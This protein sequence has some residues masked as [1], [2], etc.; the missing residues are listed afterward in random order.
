MKKKTAFIALLSVFAIGSSAGAVMASGCSGSGRRI[1]A[2]TELEA[3][4][5]TYVIPDYDVVDNDGMILSGYNV[6]LKSVKDAD[7]E[8]LAESYGSAVTVDEAGVYSF[9][10]SAGTR[11]VKDVTVSIDFADRTA[12]V[13]NCDDSSIPK[14]FIPGNSYKVPAYTLS[15]DFVREKCWAKVFYIDEN[16]KET[17]VKVESGRFKVDKDSGTYEIRIH[18]E[19]AAGNPNDYKYARK[20]ESPENVVDNKVLYLDEKFGEKQVSC[21]QSSYTGGFISKDEEGAHAYEGESGSYKVSFNGETPTQYNEGLIVMDVPAIIDMNEYEELYMYVY[22][23]SEN[24]IIMGSQWWNDTKVPA[25]QWTKLTWNTRAWGNNMSA[26]NTKPIGLVDITGMTIRFVFDYGQKI[27]PN[28]DFYLSAMY[29]TPKIRTELE[30]GE[31]VSLNGAKYFI[32]DKIELNAVQIEGKTVDYYK[33][34]G[35]IIPG[36]SFIA[37]EEKH[38]IEVVYADGEL[39]NDNM[40]W[41]SFDELKPVGGDVQTQYMGNSDYWVMSYDVSGVNDGWKYFGVYVGGNDQ[42]VGIELSDQQHSK[43][44]GYGGAWKWG[45]GVKLPDEVYTLLRTESEPVKAVFVRAGDEIRCFIISKEKTYFV[46]AVQFS[47][48]GVSGNG[49]GYGGRSNVG[50]T[51]ENFKAVSGK[52]KTELYF[53]EYY[54]AQL[55]I[56]NVKDDGE[57]YL[58]DKVTLKPAAAPEGKLFAYI[59]VNGKR[60]YGTEFR[61]PSASTSVKIV[62]TDISEVTLGEGIVTSDGKNGLIEVP[63][64]TYVIFDYK[65]KAPSG[66]YFVG[67]KVDG[68]EFIGNEILIT[69]AQ[70]TIEPLFADKVETGGEKLNDISDE[71]VIYAKGDDEQVKWNPESVEY[72]TDFT[73]DGS[74]KAVDESGVL[75]IVTG[76]DSGENSFAF[77]NSLVENLDAYKEIYF[78]VYTEADGVKAGGWWC[79]DTALVP[80]KWTRVSF[81]RNLAPGTIDGNGDTKVWEEGIN[82]FAFRIM[83]AP[84]GITVYVTAAY[85]LPYPDATVTVADD[86]KDSL[87]VSAPANGRNYKVNETVTLTAAPDPEGLTFAYFTANGEPIEGNTYLIT[88][89]VEF[90][91]VYSEYSTLALDDGISTTDGKTGTIRVARN[92]PVYLKLTDDAKYYVAFSVNGEA[93]VGNSFIPTE[94]ITYEVTVETA[95]KNTS[96]SSQLNDVSSAAMHDKNAKL[97]FTDNVYYNGADGAVTNGGSLKITAGGGDV[98]VKATKAVGGE[99]SGYKEV[100]FYIYTLDDGVVAGTWWCNDTAAV[101]GQWTKVTVYADN[102]KNTNNNY[103]ADGVSGRLFAA[104]SKGSNF[105]YRIMGGEGK[106]VY[107]TS[108]YG[109][110]YADATVKIADDSKDSL[111][112]SDPANG[113]QYKESE[114]VT[115]TAATAPEG[116][117]FAYFTANGEPIEGSTY[118]LGAGEVTFGVVYTDISVITFGEGVTAEGA[119]DGKLT[120]GRSATVTLEFNGTVP[121]GKYFKGFAVDS[122]LIAG[123]TFKANNETHTVEAVFEDKIQTGSDKLNEI[124]TVAEDG[125]SYHPTQPDWAPEKIEYVTDVKYTGSDGAIDENGSLKVTLKGGEQA[126]ALNKTLINELDVYKEIY[127]YIY[128]DKGADVSGIKIGGWWCRDTDIVAGQWTRVSF[129]R[130]KAPQNVSEKSVWAENSIDKFVYSFEKAKAGTVVYLT[131]VY[132]VLYDEVSV[133]VEESVKNYIEVTGT[134]REGQTITLSHKSSP[135]NTEFV[136]FTVNGERYD[137]DTYTLGTA[138]VVIGAYFTEAKAVLTFGE[139]VKTSDGKNAYALGETVTL[140]IDGA[141]APSD[142]VL[143]RFEVDGKSIS[144]NTFTTTAAAHSVTAVFIDKAADMTW[145]E[146]TTDGTEEANAGESIFVKKFGNAD[147]WVMTYKVT[148]LSSGDWGSLLSVYIG[149][150]S[151]ILQISFSGSE[152]TARVYGQTYDSPIT[153]NNITLIDLIKNASAENPVDVTFVRSGNNIGVY[154]TD[155]NNVT[156]VLVNVNIGNYLSSGA[157]TDDFGYA[158]RHTHYGNPVIDI[159]YVTGEGKTGLFLDSLTADIGFTKASAEQSVYHLG[160]TVTLIAE[161]AE[162]GKK[163]LRFTVNDEPLT[164]NTF[165]VNSTERYEVVAEYSDIST[166]TLDDGV[167]TAD[168]NTEYARGAKVT[169]SFDEAKLGGK[170]VDYYIIDKGTTNEQR[171]FNGEFTTTAATH[172]VEAVL[173]DA[174]KLT[175]ADFAAE[176]VTDY[177][178]WVNFCKTGETAEDWIIEYKLTKDFTAGSIGVYLGSD[179]WAE[180][181]LGSEKKLH[182]HVGGS[183]YWTKVADLPEDVVTKLQSAGTTNV[184]LTWIRKGNTLTVVLDNTQYI[185]KFEF[186]D[187]HTGEQ[188]FGTMFRGSATKDMFGNIK[189]IVG[190]SRVNAYSDYININAVNGQ[191]SEAQINNIYNAKIISGNG[192]LEYVDMPEE[193]ADSNVKESGVMKVSVTD[194]EFA[195][196]VNSV[197]TSNLDAYKEIYFWVYVSADTDTT[198]MQAGTYWCANTNLSAGWNKITITR[199]TNWAWNGEAEVYNGVPTGVDEQKVYEVGAQ[200][201]VYRLMNCSGKT[202]YVTSLYGVPKDI[203]PVV[204]NGATNYSLV[205]GDGELTA[206][207]NDNFFPDAE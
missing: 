91:V 65:G 198:G 17:E 124:G 126:F 52:T 89:N 104:G 175:W 83:G 77:D 87:T 187:A 177:E 100:Y 152:Y 151:Q 86:C 1:D 42:L 2:P 56:D 19:D 22:N 157:A 93:I 29:A 108:L 24:D 95:D 76:S 119:A 31:N 3:D 155:K 143:D 28:G 148:D 113:T 140:V 184:T 192:T 54:K 164:G 45:D 174:D 32:N 181:E 200:V 58:G 85:G 207:L 36:D 168:G 147:K 190:E 136:Y 7:G 97:E 41:A 106:T 150:T 110:P 179:H 162:T 80:G 90:G 107:V 10:Y 109:V 23:D 142:K 88:G 6:Y 189:F 105:I 92:V 43:F 57:H 70:H 144:G 33:V 67:F 118:V 178:G 25:K 153:L 176:N 38:K 50:A 161:E 196:N 203:E 11:K 120:V 138:P 134:F 170:V 202:L 121:A 99:L 205:S 34:D 116:K 15:G 156:Y 137:K 68:K 159:K 131:A 186:G 66:K 103:D 117:A 39:T 98:A 172:T 158:D 71:N 82:K 197:F 165:T 145:C 101:K 55:T 8:E 26:N 84:A 173:A 4:L 40:T 199:D 75:K 63:Q 128:A 69:G 48:L 146:A 182:G 111:T 79:G 47:E 114:T 102:T 81:G 163:F 78:Y 46:G 16:K 61:I 183:E 94:G 180:I 14:F 122:N 13:I 18:V 132:G 149:G 160:D 169:L 59:E 194:K 20:V 195:L 125:L 30:L 51:V 49:F 72:V 9:V 115:L 123:N 185:G 37:T 12:P 204:Q 201:F 130:D 154:V 166:L 139:G 27:I 133:T 135:E 191:T 62:Y 44:A 206:I 129:T 96:A 167:L 73:F 74:D 35:K 21:Y 188:E 112:V 193:L 64:N 60:I 5:G 171:I 127:F 141:T 53:K